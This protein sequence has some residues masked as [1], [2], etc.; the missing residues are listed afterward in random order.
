M[1][2]EA[3][4]AFRRRRTQ[5]EVARE[6][7]RGESGAD[8]LRPPGERVA[9]VA[10]EGGIHRGLQVP[11]AEVPVAV[12]AEVAHGVVVRALVAQRGGALEEAVVV[13]VGARAFAVHVEDGGGLRGEARDGEVLAVGV[14]HEHVVAAHALAE[15][16]FRPELVS[17]SRRRN[18]P[19]LYCQLVVVARAEEAH[20]E[21]HV[22]EEE[23]AEVG[24]E[25]LDADAHRVEVVARRDVAQVH[26][27]E[28]FLHADVVV[29]APGARAADRCAARALPR[30]CDWFTLNAGTK[31]NS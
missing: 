2:P 24:G 22:L 10:P 25:G 16:S 7:R 21:G 23:A 19:R 29:R 8:V 12:V 28:Q 27:G 31:R 14:G 18:Q 20:A 30:R 9:L 1:S 17:F 15:T 6:L 3:A 5:L 26:V 4:S 13:V 11:A